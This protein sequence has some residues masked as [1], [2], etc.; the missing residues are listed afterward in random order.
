SEGTLAAADW[1]G[2]MVDAGHL[3]PGVDYDVMHETFESGNAAM[4]ITGPWALPR[5][6]ESGIP[7]VVTA[8]PSGTQEAQPLLGVQGFMVS[9]FSDNQVLAQAF[10]T[11]FVATEEVMQAIYE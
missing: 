2:Q 3:V 4:M 7:Y 5:I 6:R 11:E 1:L 10:L 8:I 9:A